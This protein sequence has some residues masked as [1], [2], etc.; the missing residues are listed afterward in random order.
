MDGI[1]DAAVTAWLRARRPGVVPPL[2]YDTIAGGRSNLTYDVAD[3]DGRRFVLRR[4]PLHSVLASA[5]DV[6]RE[7]RIM[8]ALAGSAVPVPPVVG[9]ET[10]DAVNG[11]PFYVM[12]FVDGLVVRDADVAAAELTAD[13]RREA[14]ASLVDTLLAL[15]GVDVDAVGLGD[16]GRRDGYVERQLK[17]WSG[18]LEKGSDRD[19]SVLVDVGRRLAADVPAAQR[20]TI[21]HGDYRLDNVIVDPASPG[22]PVTAVLDWELCTL[23]DPMA[24]LG[25]LHVYWAEGGDEELQP[26]GHM[27]TIVDGFMSRAEVFERYAAG[28][29]LDLSELDYYVAFALWRLAIILEGVFQRFSAGA[30]EHVDEGVAAM[31]DTVLQLGEAADE[32]ARAVGR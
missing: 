22:T 1:N 26:L 32:A 21:V 31:G 27:P 7:A 3:A 5:H 19:L 2:S 24:D 20:S 13:Q 28:S 9:A 14:S 23:G 18:Q 4:P 17:R 8:S 11:A 16:L 10:D 15:H 6:G 25:T 29:D 30:Y 12:D